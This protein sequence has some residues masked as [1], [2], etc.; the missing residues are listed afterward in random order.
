[1]ICLLNRFRYSRNERFY[2]IINLSNQELYDIE[3]FDYEE[4][5]LDEES[6]MDLMVGKEIEVF[7]SS[8]GQPIVE[9]LV[10][11]NFFIDIMTYGFE[12]H[13]LPKFNKGEY[14][15]IRTL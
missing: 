8:I 10:N 2:G 9:Y 6:V 12:L 14:N 3:N 1:M 13:D 7:M 15:P 4:G 5:T 11:F